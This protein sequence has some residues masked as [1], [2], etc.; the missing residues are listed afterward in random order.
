MR[1][2]LSYLVFALSVL[3]LQTGPTFAGPHRGEDVRWEGVVERNASKLWIH[4]LGDRPAEASLETLDGGRAA[5]AELIQVAAGAG[6]EVPAASPA[7][8]GRLRLRSDADLFILQG[9]EELD[10]RSIEIAGAP[11]V[12]HDPARKGPGNLLVRPE[13]ARNLIAGGPTLERGKTGFVSVASEDP[14]ARVSVAVVFREPDSAARIRLLDDEGRE[15]S[16][17]VASSSKAV[18]WRATLGRIPSGGSGGSGRVEVQ[19][20]AGRVHATATAKGK[21]DPG[22]PVVIGMSCSGYFNHDINWWHT[23]DL[24][25]SVAG[26]P[27]NTCGDL[28]T[29]RNGGGWQETQGWLCT[30]GS[31]N[32]TKG[33]WTYAGQSGDETA[34]AYIEFPSTTTNVSSHIWDKTAPSVYITSSWGAPPSSFYGSANDA[35]WG[36]GFDSSWASCLMAFEHY[37]SGTSTYKYWTP[38]SGGTYSTTTNI[39]VPCTISG[40]PSLN[41]TW[42]GGSSIPGTSAHQSGE[43][44]TWYVWLYD[45]GQWGSNAIGFCS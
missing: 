34:Y 3:V 20:L 27:A 37:D 21:K 5:A 9:P 16:S 8:G 11:L 30:D 26:C 18:E 43:C 22:D 42:S 44:Y 7:E 2:K 23:S 29:Y 10:V 32:A 24:Y 6:V 41:V 40:M 33:P 39:Y 19:V 45:G 13:W 4:N 31:G 38:T 35:A 17:V 25:Y 36:A 1:Q 28:W 14:A 15:V 12:R